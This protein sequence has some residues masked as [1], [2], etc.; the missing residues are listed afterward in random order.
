MLLSGVMYEE[1]WKAVYL[2][3]MATNG[4]VNVTFFFTML[5]TLAKLAFLTT[6]TA[7]FSV[8]SI[9]VPVIS[10]VHMHLTLSFIAAR[11]GLKAIP[12]CILAHYGHNICVLKFF[13]WG[14][15]SLLVFI[16]VAWAV[17]CY[18]CLYQWKHLWRTDSLQD[19]SASSRSSD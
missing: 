8:L 1:A 14:W 18:S 13:E 2:L 19:A 7:G 12:L 6:N 15:F 5:E 10:T 16:S 9:L 11:F 17:A 4:L 3:V